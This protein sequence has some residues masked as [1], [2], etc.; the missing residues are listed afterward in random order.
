MKGDT[1]IKV[2]TQVCVPAPRTGCIGINSYR[3]P[4]QAGKE[5]LSC[6]AIAVRFGLTLAQLQDLNPGMVERGGVCFSPSKDRHICQG[7]FCQWKTQCGARQALV[8][9]ACHHWVH[10]W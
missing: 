8:C 9:H 6:T 2:G 4:L 3:I 10:I 5:Y 1:L 7:K